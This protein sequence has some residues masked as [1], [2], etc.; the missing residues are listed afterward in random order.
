MAHPD[1][2]TPGAR[3][4]SLLLAD[5]PAISG[6]A[7]ART[8]PVG[9]ASAGSTGTKKR[10]R[11]LV[12]LM[13]LTVVL[14]GAG[15]GGFLLLRASGMMAGP[16]SPALSFSL[17]S[18]P[19][20]GTPAA[21]PSAHP[22][23]HPVVRPRRK[24]A[25]SAVTATPG[26]TDKV[27]PSRKTHRAFVSR[28]AID[29][30]PVQV[31]LTVRGGGSR[32]IQG[33]FEIRNNGT[34]PIAGWEIALSLPGDVI[35]SVANASEQSSDGVLLLEP[36]DAAEVVPPHGGTLTVRFTAEGTQT[37]PQACGFNEIACA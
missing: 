28:P 35:V 14:T 4:L 2:W 17:P 36:L 5:P 16:R 25:P 31:K 6:P 12:T 22:A 23:A 33:Q 18:M 21:R 37:V 15:V 20:F 3:S 19:R 9:P 7:P 11:V 8:A 34:Q 30:A 10:H 13:A 26:L 27:T 32:P 24:T 29:G 1:R